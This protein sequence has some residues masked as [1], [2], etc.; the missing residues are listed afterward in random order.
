MWSDTLERAEHCPAELSQPHGSEA[1]WPQASELCVWHWGE[2]GSAGWGNSAG[3]IPCVL[4]S[5]SCFCGICREQWLERWAGS[6]MEMGLLTTLSKG[7]VNDT[8][9]KPECLPVFFGNTVVSCQTSYFFWGKKKKG[10]SSSDWVTLVS[11][12]KVLYCWIMRRSWRLVLQTALPILCV[13]HP[14]VLLK[15]NYFPCLQLCSSCP[16]EAQSVL[17]GAVCVL[18]RWRLW[19]KSCTEKPLRKSCAPWISWRMPTFPRWHCPA[20]R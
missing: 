13:V 19:T 9:V 18:S 10:W 15:S 12:G 5:L 2:Y 20:E 16:A 3:L 1:Q 4:I 6:D 17:A 8:A 14:S 7:C 11:Y